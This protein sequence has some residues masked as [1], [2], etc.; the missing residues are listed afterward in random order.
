MI[1]DEE[2]N[3]TYTSSTYTKEFQNKVQGK[4]TCPS[5]C[6]PIKKAGRQDFPHIIAWPSINQDMF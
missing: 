6:F 3:S 4:V 2:H 1:K 5:H